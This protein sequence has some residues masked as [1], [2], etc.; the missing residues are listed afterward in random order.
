MTSHDVVAR[1]RK[2]LKMKKVGHAGTL[3]PLAT[4]V[5][6]VCLGRATRLSNYLTGQKKRY[7]ARIQLGVETDTLDADGTVVA[8]SDQLPETSQEIETAIVPFRGTTMQ[9]PP[10]YSA[11]KVDGERLH[12]LARAGKVVERE[13]REIEIYSLEILAYESPFLDLDVLCSKGTY[14]RSLASDIGSALGCG[15]SVTSLRRSQSGSISEG[16]CVQMDA[17]ADTTVSQALID[18]NDALVE[19]PACS[20][21]DAEI[22]RFAHG[23]TVVLESELGS[24]CRVTDTSGTFWGIG[25]TDQ[26]GLLRPECVLREIGTPREAHPA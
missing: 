7:R 3:D 21:D 26:P 14:I 17:V 8:V 24:P 19:L 9:V 12:K 23:N 6:V 10:M 2:A 13:A 11:R 15:G 22:M 18:P 1:V 4:G 16:H 25:R 20:L 5:L